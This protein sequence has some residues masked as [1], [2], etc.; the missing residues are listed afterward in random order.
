MSVALVS[1]I[2]SCRSVGVLRSRAHLN[3]HFNPAVTFVALIY[4][5]EEQLP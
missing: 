5:K 1:N 4:N 3:G 2:I